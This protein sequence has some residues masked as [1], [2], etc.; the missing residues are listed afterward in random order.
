MPLKG[1]GRC[2]S[3]LTQWAFSAIAS[4]GAHYFDQKPLLLIKHKMHVLCAGVLLLSE[5]HRRQFSG[6]DHS[7]ARCCQW[8]DT[9]P[10]WAAYTRSAAMY[11]QQAHSLTHTKVH[12]EG[13]NKTTFSYIYIHT[14]TTLYRIKYTHNSSSIIFKPHSRCH[15]HLAGPLVWPRIF[16]TIMYKKSIRSE[17]LLVLRGAAFVLCLSHC[18]CTPNAREISVCVCVCDEKSSQLT[19]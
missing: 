6:S 1:S 19:S 9:L 3:I 15:I 13:W 4:R 18:I 2:T 8:M 10:D 16:K 5:P 7:R 11:I 17:V 12:H 14:H